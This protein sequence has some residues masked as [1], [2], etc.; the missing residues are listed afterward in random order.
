MNMNQ[1]NLNLNLN[2]NIKVKRQTLAT[3]EASTRPSTQPQDYASAN[4][5]HDSLSYADAETGADKDKTNSGGD[6]EILHISEEQGEDVDNQ[7][8]LEEKT[9]ELDEGQAGSDPGK[10]PESRPPSEQVLMEEDQA[11]PDPGQSHVALAGPNPESMHD[12]FISTIYPQDLPHK[13]N[14]TVNEV[15]KEVVHVAFQAPLRDRFRELPEADMKEILHQWMFE[16]GS[17]RTQPKHVSLYEALEASME[18]A[19]R[20]NSDLSKKKRHDSDASSLTQPLAP[21][22]LAMKTSDTREA[23]SSSSKQK[24]APH[25]KQPVEDVPI[26]D[27]V[28]ILDSKDTDMAHLLKIKTRPDWL[29]HVP[30]EDRPATPEPDWVIP[31]NDLPETENN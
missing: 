30:E 19:N 23:P 3:K 14:Q 13:I 12:D 7:V 24:S 28:N 15:V 17:Y 5:V 27:D 26:L 22:S 9:I 1:L 8:N 21:Q 20:T 11:G 10:T 29:K 25:S 31:P 16:S 6:T 2:P 18:R 4:I